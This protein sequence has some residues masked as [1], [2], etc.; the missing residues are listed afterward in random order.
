MEFLKAILGEQ[1]DSFI[2]T[3]NA[4]NAN[5]ENKDKQVQIVNLNAGEYVKK[6]D[7]E[8]LEVEKNNL[9]TN[10]DT[11]KKT[12]KGFEGVDVK[13]LQGEIKKLTGELETKETEHQQ[14]IS[15][16]KFDASLE[17]AIM[18]A[19]ARNSKTVKALLDIKALKD[20]KNQE[21]D[22]KTALETCKTDNDYLFGANEPIN[23]QVGPTG[24]DTGNKDSNEAMI[25][26][27][28]G[29]P[30]EK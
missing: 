9:Q 8:A 27:V 4:Y 5:P 29:L 15:D 28:M 1:Y 10:Y 25:R 6:S 12:L 14:Q 22:I 2:K 19:G 18:A 13:E 11:A 24:G 30:E 3:V 21:A 7:Y 20:S 23:N 17:A 16:M 26:A